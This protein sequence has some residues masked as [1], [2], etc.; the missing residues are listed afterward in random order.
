MSISV[1]VRVVKDNVPAVIAQ[2]GREEHRVSWDI[3]EHIR[4]RAEANAPVDTGNLKRRIRM[5]EVGD[6][7]QVLSDT[8]D[9]EQ[10]SLIWST[11]RDYAYYVEFGSRSNSPQPYMTPAA[12]AGVG[13][14]PVAGNRM[15]ARI[16]RVARV[17][18]GTGGVVG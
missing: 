14:I 5:H 11:Q 8:K 6:E 2:L 17:G 7:V 10:P 3:G 16:E 13:H 12:M 18:G 1:R 4:N 15:G 9:P